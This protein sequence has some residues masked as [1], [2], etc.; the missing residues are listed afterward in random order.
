MW[1][2]CPAPAGPGGSCLHWGRGAPGP[3]AAALTWARE[4]DE[5]GRERSLCP[6]C[7]RRHLR[8][9]EAGLAHEWW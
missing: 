1:R 5:R 8:D 3:G 7:A 2:A 9:I 6:A 4:R